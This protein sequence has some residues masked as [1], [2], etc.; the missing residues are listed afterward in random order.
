MFKS[1]TRRRTLA[2]LT[3][4]ALGSRAPFAQNS[5]GRVLVL[6]AT[7]RIG[8]FIAE[9][10]R[11]DGYTVRAVTRDAARAESRW[12]GMYEWVEADVR[13]PRT[14][15][16]P[17]QGVDYI[18]SSIRSSEWSGPYNPEFVDYHGMR[19]LV[20]AAKSANV[21]HFVLISTAT[22]G[23]QV[24]QSKNPAKNYVRYFKTKGEEYLRERGLSWTIIAPGR[25]PEEPGGQTGF[26]LLDRKD[27]FVANI[28]AGDVA[29]VALDALTNPA[30]RGK[31]FGL[32]NVEDVPLGAWR[33]DYAAMPDK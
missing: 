6:G 14:L 12:P 15:L 23:P 20:D 27:Y 22:S 4:A 24:D 28:N 25:V 31:A 13:D 17:L 32:R 21:K 26:I 33:N 1:F 29:L 30:A 2:T 11:A 9:T 19:N 8:R 5:K 16:A 18:V 7:G 10:I 3:A